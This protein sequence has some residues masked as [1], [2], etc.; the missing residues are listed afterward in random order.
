MLSLWSLSAF[1]QNI[2]LPLQHDHINQYESKIHHIDSN[3]HTSMKPYISKRIYSIMNNSLEELR[4]DSNLGN[5]KVG[6]ILFNK[7]LFNIY[8]EDD[9]NITGDLLL[10]YSSGFASD[11][12]Y[13]MFIRG[14]RIEGGIGK[15]ISFSSDIY[16]V[17]AT[18]PDYIR[19]R[20]TF[21]RTFLGNG[22]RRVYEAAN[23]ELQ[24]DVLN[25]TGQITYEADKYFQVQLGHGKNFIGDGYRSM[26]L[27]DN[28]TFYPYLKLIT[29]FWNI[30]YTNLY[31]SMFDVRSGLNS[32]GIWPRKYITSHHLS[33]NVSPRLNIGLFETVIYQDSS[34]R[35]GFD[36]HYLN[37]VIFYRPI[38]YEI[39]SRGGNSLI[40]FN[41]KYKITNDIYAYGQF[42][43]DEFS[44]SRNEVDKGCWCNKYGWQLGIK[45]F[46]TIIPNLTV[47]TEV[48]SATFYT[49]SHEIPLQNYAN[50]NLAL[51]HPLGANFIE[52]MSIIRYQKER[53]TGKFQFM[54]ALQG[55]DTLGSHWGADINQPFENHEQDYGNKLLQ[56]VRTTRTYADIALGYIINPRSN[57][58]FELGYRYRGFS[59]DIEAGNLKGSVDSFVYIG[60]KTNFI[61][62]YYDY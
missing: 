57:F 16:L 17:N 18:V 27:S 51:A 44:L 23:G 13:G 37:P 30:Q 6:N 19:N 61:N 2:V 38:E 42:I 52:S 1:T 26:L 47:Q 34:S 14:G 43:F 3:F 22:T 4:M 36:L 8:E 62:W 32:L 28:S 54:Y 20:N 45:S 10:G 41:A 48:N 25:A 29:S 50:S 55:L 46:N 5:S 9:Y 60:F 39:G 15:K 40:G 12:S 21:T 53:F 49:Y 59:P 56:G 33:W 58:H 31:T 24:E 7:N 11:T 35:R